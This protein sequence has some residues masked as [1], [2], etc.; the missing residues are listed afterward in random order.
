VV[1][2]INRAL[3]TPLI[4]TDAAAIALGLIARIDGDVVLKQRVRLR[5]AAISFQRP[6]LQIEHRNLCGAS[7]AG[8]QRRQLP[9]V[10]RSLSAVL[11][12]SLPEQL[13]PDVLLAIRVFV[14][15]TL[16]LPKPQRPP[17]ELPTSVLLVWL[18][19]PSSS[20]ISPQLLAELSGNV[21]IIK[22]TIPLKLSM[23]P[24]KRGHISHYGAAVCDYLAAGGIADT[25]AK[26]SRVAG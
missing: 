19:V 22:R 16:A 7:A 4:G 10:S 15:S 20:L 24:P 11:K 2:A 6:E 26:I 1:I 3:G 25:R 8:R 12:K 18:T 5:T 9:S 21:M 14:M 17:P 13:A 23:P